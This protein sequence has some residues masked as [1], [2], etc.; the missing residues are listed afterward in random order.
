MNAWLKGN[1]QGSKEEEEEEEEE[2]E[3][4][5]LLLTL[6]K[7]EKKD[8]SEPL[9]SKTLCSWDM[10]HFLADS[11]RMQGLTIDADDGEC[12]LL[13]VCSLFL[14]PTKPSPQASLLAMSKV[15]SLLVSSMSSNN[16]TSDA[17]PVLGDVYYDRDASLFFSVPT[18]FTIQRFVARMAAILQRVE[19]GKMLRESRVEVKLEE[20][21]G[22]DYESIKPLAEAYI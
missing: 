14:W 22:F 17:H 10:T 7:G 18:L 1:A 11:I 12:V 21:D 5:P 20:K 13:L 19:N 8:L 15:E 16:K 6:N 3:S 4:A 9:V 2:K